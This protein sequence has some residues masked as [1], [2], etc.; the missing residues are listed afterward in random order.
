MVCRKGDA[1]YSTIQAAHQSCFLPNTIRDHA[2]FAFKN[3]YQ[4][5][6]NKG[7]T[8]Y[9]NIAHCYN[10]QRLLNPTSRKGGVILE[11]CGNL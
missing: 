11:I 7:A 10:H 5:F 9:F 6:K 3:Y 4:K 1:D 2:S 8:C